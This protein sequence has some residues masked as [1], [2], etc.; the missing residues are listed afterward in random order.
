MRTWIRMLTAAATMVAWWFGVTPL[1]EP[2][3]LDRTKSVRTADGAAHSEPRYI[4]AGGTSV[5]G[6]R[7]MSRRTPR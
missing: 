7:Q 5:G 2:P 3:H 1:G 4:L 6:D